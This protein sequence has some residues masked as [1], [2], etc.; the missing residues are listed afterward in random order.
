MV[1]DVVCRLP[2]GCTL[3]KESNGVGGYR[4]W[5]DEVGGGVCIWDTSIVA[6]S[7]LLA[8]LT[9]EARAQ[10]EEQTGKRYYRTGETKG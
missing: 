9:E 1:T 3:Y 10:H 8:A 7:T 6:S 5:S 4:Y 2:N